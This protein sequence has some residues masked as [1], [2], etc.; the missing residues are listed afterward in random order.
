M[1]AAVCAGFPAASLGI[2]GSRAHVVVRCGRCRTEYAA[3]AWQEL[4]FVERIV[5][6]NIRGLVTSWP[7]GIAIEIRRCPSCGASIARKQEKR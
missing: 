6:D 5:A 3:E 4:G 7:E 1:G 2:A